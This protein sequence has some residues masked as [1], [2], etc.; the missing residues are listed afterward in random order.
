MN[1]RLSDPQTFPVIRQRYIRH[2]LSNRCQCGR[3]CLKD[4]E[5]A[6]MESSLP[7]LVHQ[8][9]QI[10]RIDVDLQPHPL[11]RDFP[12]A[13]LKV[14]LNEIGINHRSPLVLL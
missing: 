6:R 10:G 2:S 14:L 11:W 1:V 3:R 12:E 9:E 13:T 7:K 8:L 4:F 5:I